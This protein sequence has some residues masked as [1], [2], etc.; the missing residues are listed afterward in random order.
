MRSTNREGHKVYAQAYMYAFILA[1]GLDG[2]VKRRGRVRKNW[3]LYLL[4]AGRGVAQL[5]PF[6]QVVR[7]YKL[8]GSSS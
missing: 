8:N 5:S 3:Q 7:V 6:N 4:T 2:E 1:R